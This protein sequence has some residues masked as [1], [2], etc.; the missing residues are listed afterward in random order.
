MSAPIDNNIAAEIIAEQEAAHLREI[1]RLDDIAY[2]F[3]RG[4]DGD[5][6]EA[7]KAL[8]DCIEVLFEGGALVMW[9]Y[10]VV[11]AKIRAGL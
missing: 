11:L 8:D 10:R 9:K 1:R 7:E 2:R 5:H 6:V 3:L 4:A